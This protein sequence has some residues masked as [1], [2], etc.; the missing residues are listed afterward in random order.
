MRDVGVLGIGQTPVGEHWD[1][2][3]RDLAVDAARAALEEAGLD[4]VDAVYVGNM[5]SGI[6]CG[7]ENLATLVADAAGLLPAEAVKI[8]AACA[9]GGAAVRAGFQVVAG[10]CTSGC[11]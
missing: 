6:L 10:G 1:R 2:S 11:W 5:A 9:S 8:E 4:R 7:Q 3:L